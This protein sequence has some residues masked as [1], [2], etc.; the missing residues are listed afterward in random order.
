MSKTNKKSQRQRN[1]TLHKRYI[2]KQKVEKGEAH[3][4]RKG[5][6]IPAK[7][8]QP[9]VCKCKLNCSTVIEVTRQRQI[10]DSYY[11]TMDW[12]SKTNFLRASV[13][14]I[15]VKSRTSPQPQKFRDFNTLYRFTDAIG[16]AHPVCKTF[17]INCLQI[18]GSRVLLAL[19]TMKSNPNAVDR[20]GKHPSSK[21]ISESDANF[22]MEFIKGYPVYEACYNMKRPVKKYLRTNLSVIKL[23]KD[24]KVVCE[25][26]QRTV[27]KENRFRDVFH[28]CDLTFKSLSTGFEKCQICN[29]NGIEPGQ[30]LPSLEDTSIGPELGEHIKCV[31]DF[32]EAFKRDVDEAN[33]SED[34][35]QCL[36]FE[37]QRAL[38]TPYLHRMD[39]TLTKRPLWTYNLCIYDEISKQAYMYVWGE[40][41]AGHGAEEIGSCLVYHIKNNL[42][43]NTKHLILYSDSRSQKLSLKLT[44]I[45][46]KLLH[47]TSGEMQ[48]ETIEQKYFPSGH[49][50]NSCDLKFFCTIEKYIKSVKDIFSPLHWQKIIFD[51]K[52]LEP[53]FK[54]TGMV[55]KDFYTC[56]CI[57]NL[58]IP[59]KT[60][61]SQVKWSSLYAI[62]NR[63]SEPLILAVKENANRPERKIQLF[64]ANVTE[65]IFCELPL[66]NSHPNGKLINKKKYDDLMDLLGML[67][68]KCHKFYKNLQYNQNENYDIDFGLASGSSEDD[69]DDHKS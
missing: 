62:T 41:V 23:Y 28:R 29:D 64:K 21:K 35:V 65:D 6:V 44:L 57:R 37:L 8:F 16:I 40:N 38:P 58:C 9:Q 56:R 26:A 11:K 42:P 17:F 10:F 68:K 45:L 63:K 31:H 13:Q 51:S 2:D 43:V 18:P 61:K 27:L 69:D 14:Q 32:N 66:E 49:T 55:S 19:K 36:T 33:R 53:R 25:T 39:E 48:I 34:A 22:A 3:V 67:P 50:Y 47:N 1:D 59:K 4:T 20:R 60:I 52:K 24:Y 5:A 12:S 30:N 46:K 15:P 7:Q 54:V